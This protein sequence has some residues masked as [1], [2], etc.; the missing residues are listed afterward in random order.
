[1]V[2]GIHKEWEK[3]D[4]ALILQLLA[5]PHLARTVAEVLCITRSAQ[6]Y[7]KG[8]EVRKVLLKRRQMK[9]N[10]LHLVTFGNV[11]FE[12]EILWVT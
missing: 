10:V 7:N 1:M 9:W 3:D 6:A 11:H 5:K 4:H 8:P 2:E 12:N